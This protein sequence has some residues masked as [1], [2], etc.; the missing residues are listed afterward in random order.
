MIFFRR[1]VFHKY[2][3]TYVLDFTNKKTKILLGKYE[4]L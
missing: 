2:Y 4:K 3:V 1:K